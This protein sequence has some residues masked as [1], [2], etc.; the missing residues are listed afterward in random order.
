M[1]TGS[2][3]ESTTKKGSGTT[4]DTSRKKDTKPSKKLTKKSVEKIASE[5]LGR[6]WRQTDSIIVTHLNNGDYDKAISYIQKN[7]T[8]EVEKKSQDS[9]PVG[10]RATRKSIETMFR[11]LLGQK[12]Y[13]RVATRVTVF[14]TVAEAEKALNKDMKNTR[15][16]VLV[17]VG[18]GSDL[19]PNQMDGVSNYR[20]RGKSREKDKMY[21]VLENIPKEKSLQYL[22]TK[23]A[24]I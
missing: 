3:A 4:I 20:E 6:N 9:T 12:V 7:Q 10:P 8:R 11:N 14:D 18:V 19:D 13:N 23:L 22:C 21:F 17:Q 1:D 16:S 2:S 5:I 15:G 24:L